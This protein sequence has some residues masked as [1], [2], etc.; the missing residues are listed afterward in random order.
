MTG[1]AE[2]ETGK[3]A[4]SSSG[5]C[6]NL[7]GQRILACNHWPIGEY[8]FIRGG[9]NSVG[10]EIDPGV[11]QAG[12]RYHYINRRRFTHHQVGGEHN[13]VLIVNGGV[14]IV[15]VGL[16]RGLAIRFWIDRCTETDRITDAVAGAVVRQQGRIGGRRITEIKQCLINDVHRDGSR[17]GAALA[18]FDG[19]IEGVLPGGVGCK[20]DLAG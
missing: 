6:G 17:G 18:I 9:P 4:C 2:A 20:V 8:L 3:G 14:Q 7:E 13:A 10:I 16:G 5:C 15:A 12:G 19:V 11:E 1:S